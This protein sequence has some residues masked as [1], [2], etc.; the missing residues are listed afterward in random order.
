LH[1]LTSGDQDDLLH[2]PVPI[3]LETRLETLRQEHRIAE[4]AYEAA[5]RVRRVLQSAI[6]ARA[7]GGASSLGTWLESVWKALGGADTVN[8]EEREN[9]RL[10][11]AAMDRLEGGEL[12]LLGPELKTALSTLCAQPDPSTSSDFGVQLMTIHKSKGLEFEV[13]LVPDL[14]ASGQKQDRTLVSWLERGLTTPGSSEI[15]EF[16]VAPIQFKGEKAGPAKR[17]VDGVKGERERQ[18]MRRLLYVAST[19]AREELHL[20]ARPRY[21]QGKKAHEGGRML[22]APSGLL[23]TAWPA[24]QEEVEARFAT[25]VQ[26]EEQDAALSLAAAAVNPGEL[27]QLELPLAGPARPLHLRRLPAG[28]AVPELR[29]LGTAGRGLGDSASQEDER[30]EGLYARTEGGLGSRLEGTAIHFLLERL[31]ELRTGLEPAEAAEKLREALLPTVAMI[32]S[33]GLPKGPAHNLADQ[34]LAM[35]QWASTDEAGA[36]VLAPHPQAKTEARWTGL[37]DGQ[38]RNLRPDRVFLAPA[39][40]GRWLDAIAPSASQEPAWWIIDYKTSRASGVDLAVREERLAYL[41]ARRETYREQLA[42][43]GQL[44]RQL[45][46]SDRPGTDIPPIRTGVFYPRLRLFDCW[47]A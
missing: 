14:E 21:S 32:R 17:W 26:K 34:A 46:L 41:A 5:A 40:Q 7:A 42:A 3:L 35:V 4:R 43:Y 36:W 31:A 15:T 30:G 6:N 16:L 8:A 20:F 24:V 37:W 22:D 47:D 39:P 27:I 12:D 11:W 28:H 33:H 1:Q 38:T 10:L 13:V 23:K 45:L 29:W 19:R 9:L 44:L 2:Q 18:E 25:W